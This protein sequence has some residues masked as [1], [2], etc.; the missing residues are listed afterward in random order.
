MAEMT[1]K[2]EGEF[3]L[4]SIPAAYFNRTKQTQ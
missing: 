1:A 3:L 2:I 4:T